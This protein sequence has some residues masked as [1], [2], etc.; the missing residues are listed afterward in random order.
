MSYSPQQNGNSKPQ[1]SSSEIE[2]TNADMVAFSAEIPKIYTRL[3]MLSSPFFLKQQQPRGTDFDFTVFSGEATKYSPE[4]CIRQ[5]SIHCK[6]ATCHVHDIL[7]AVVERCDCPDAFVGYDRL[8]DGTSIKD[9]CVRIIEEA[10]DATNRHLHIRNDNNISLP[11]RKIVAAVVSYKLL[12]V[13]C[14]LYRHHLEH[15]MASKQ[16]AHL[17]STARYLFSYVFY[18]DITT[19]NNPYIVPLEGFHQWILETPPP[20]PPKLPLQEVNK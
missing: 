14:H 1:A 2:E 7:H 6:R 3:R 19:E 20:D 10:E 5:L 16:T 17:N 15:I 12:W 18:F 9:T 4:E 8:L 11:L 13:I